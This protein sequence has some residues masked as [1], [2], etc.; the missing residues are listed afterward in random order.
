MI[1]FPIEWVKQ[2]RWEGESKKEDS[3]IEGFNGDKF[4]EKP[5]VGEGRGGWGRGRKEKRCEV[6]LRKMQNETESTSSD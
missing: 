5:L 1:V 6:A 3:L 4:N 2:R